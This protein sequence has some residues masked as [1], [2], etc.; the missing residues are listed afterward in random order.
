MHIAHFQHYAWPWHAH[1]TWR[2][3]HYIAHFQPYDWPWHRMEVHMQDGGI[4]ILHMHI[5]YCT[6]PALRLTLTCT[7]HM[8]EYA[9]YCTCPALGL[10]LTSEKCA[11]AY[12]YAGWRNM[13]NAYCTLPALRLTLTSEK[14]ASNDL[15]TLLHS[16]GWANTKMG[17]T[18]K[19]AKKT[20]MGKLKRKQKWEN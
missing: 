10:T 13:H 17:K 3:M 4:C 12:V 2:N 18:K 20:K 7:F 9:L 6:F 15:H 16:R 8:E 19:R 11:Y 14:G 5:A 1:F